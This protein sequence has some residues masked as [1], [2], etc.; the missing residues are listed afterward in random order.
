MVNAL[1]TFEN[2]MTG[3]IIS[4]TCIYPAF[5]HRIEV[6]GEKGTAM[7]NGEYDQVCLSLLPE[8]V[9]VELELMTHFND[10]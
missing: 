1:V 9:N 2:G 3:N 6:H 7:M 5:K 10:E 8:V 4:S